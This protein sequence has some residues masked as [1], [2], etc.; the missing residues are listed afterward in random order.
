MADAIDKSMRDADTDRSDGTSTELDAASNG[1]GA[2]PDSPSDDTPA[3]RNSV[4]DEDPGR[5]FRTWFWMILVAGYGLFL[6]FGSV[7]AHYWV[8]NSYVERGTNVLDV[9]RAQVNGLPDVAHQTVLKT[10]FLISAFGFIG[11]AVVALWLASVVVRPDLSARVND[12]D[13]TDDSARRPSPA[14]G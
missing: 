2:I 13:G 5:Y 1:V 7:E 10:V 3:S 11:L 9:W 12:V 8:R 6:V 4:S 14:A